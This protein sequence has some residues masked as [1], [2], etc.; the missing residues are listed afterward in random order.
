MPQELKRYLPS[1]IQLMLVAACFLQAC[2]GIPH[3]NFKEIYGGKVGKHID[4]PNLVNGGYPAKK[5]RSHALTSGL[6]ETLYEIQNPWGRCLVFFKSNPS[7]G[8]IEAWRFEG[9]DKECSIPP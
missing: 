1:R 4:D 6:V 8:I 5:V 7:T 9:S 2:A 3:D